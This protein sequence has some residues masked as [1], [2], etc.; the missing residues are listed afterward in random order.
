MT[1]MS[2]VLYIIL[3]RLL[4]LYLSKLGCDI[5]SILLCIILFDDIFAF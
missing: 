1:D 5:L 4:L 3:E 2:E